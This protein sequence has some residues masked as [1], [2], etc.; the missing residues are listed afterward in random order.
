MGKRPIQNSDGIRE[1]GEKFWNFSQKIFRFF[2]L[3]F[4]HYFIEHKNVTTPPPLNIKKKKKISLFPNSFDSF[5]KVSP[6]VI[7]L[8]WNFVQI[9]FRLFFLQEYGHKTFPIYKLDKLLLKFSND[10]FFFF[11]WW[12]GKT[13][14]LRL[15]TKLK[16]K[17]KK[18]SWILD[19]L[20][21]QC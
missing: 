14:K 21:G 10:S 19:L 5:V 15:H 7:I 16:F 6:F 12:V 18:K 8:P 20:V 3:M 13:L 1:K 4:F 17:K 9:F 11:F 2:F